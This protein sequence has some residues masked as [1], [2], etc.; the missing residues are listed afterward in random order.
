[1]AAFMPGDDGPVHPNGGSI[2]HGA[3]I[4][5]HPPA[6]PLGRNLKGTLDTRHRGER[7]DHQCRSSPF[8]ERREPGSP[9]GYPISDNQRCSSPMFSSSTRNFHHP[10]RFAQ[11]VARELRPGIFRTGTESFLREGESCKE[12]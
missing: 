6:G 7:K 3:E 10:F 12:R 1:M 8:Q 9:S 4:Q 2:I 5:Q 11:S